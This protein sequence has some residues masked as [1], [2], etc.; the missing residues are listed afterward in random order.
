MQEST[1]RP[2]DREATL[3]SQHRH[4]NYNEACGL[5]STLCGLQAAFTGTVH[6]WLVISRE[7]AIVP[8]VRDIWLSCMDWLEGT[9][10]V[11][12]GPRAVLGEGRLP[13]RMMLW[14]APVRSCLSARVAFASLSCAGVP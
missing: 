13:P 14:P 1:P 8:T 5:A 4:R 10:L 11:E 12:P 3:N 6:T 9:L 2:D 7:A